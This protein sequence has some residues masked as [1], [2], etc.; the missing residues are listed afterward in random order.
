MLITMLM[1]RDLLKILLCLLD[2][3]FEYK[4]YGCKITV[5]QLQVF[6]FINLQ[7]FERHTHRHTHTKAHTGS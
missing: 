7:V 5:T 3:T 1:G 4:N 6:G 2:L